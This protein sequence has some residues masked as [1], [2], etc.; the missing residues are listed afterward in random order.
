M[1]IR[2]LPP[3]QPALQQEEASVTH[4]QQTLERLNFK[5]QLQHA[6]PQSGR[7]GGLAGAVHETKPLFGS[8]IQTKVSKGGL[9]A[10]AACGA[11]ACIAKAALA[12]DHVIAARIQ[13]LL[14]PPPCPTPPYNAYPHQNQ[15]HP[16]RIECPPFPRPRCASNRN[17]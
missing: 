14:L 3:P 6:A 16:G 2:L 4:A 13:L 1:T 8:S 17:C 10:G 15:A 5:L 12:L 9:R 11:F 7:G